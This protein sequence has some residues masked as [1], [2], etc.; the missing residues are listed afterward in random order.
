M[1]YL[2]DSYHECNHNYIYLYINNNLLYHHITIY[3]LFSRKKI[4]HQSNHFLISTSVM[5]ANMCENHLLFGF[6]HRNHIYQTF[7]LCFLFW[8]A[9]LSSSSNNQ[10]INQSINSLFLK[11]IYLTFTLCFLFWEAKLSIN[12]QI[13]YHFYPYQH[14]GTIIYLSIDQRSNIHHHFSS[15]FHSAKIFLDALICASDALKLKSTTV[16]CESA[17]THYA[18]LCSLKA[19]KFILYVLKPHLH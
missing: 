6:Y 3:F 14:D 10:S 9:K 8:E 16:Y 19:L 1:L 12:H 17:K 7:T 4:Y 18:G 5:N 15:H 2:N 11:Q 13:F